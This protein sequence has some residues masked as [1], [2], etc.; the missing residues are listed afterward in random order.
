MSSYDPDNS[1]PPRI[2]SQSTDQPPQTEQQSRVITPARI[3]EYIGF[4]QCPR[5]FKHTV[6]EINSSL[7]HDGGEFQESF[8]PLNILL[9]KAGEEFEE[10]VRDE[11]LS[12]EEALVDL[13]R[14]AEYFAPDDD[15]I[16]EVLKSACESPATSTEPTIL[17]Q[18][19][20][21]DR[22]GGWQVAGDADL[23]LSW[24]TDDGAKARVIHVKSAQEK[25]SYHQIQAATY[26]DLLRRLVESSGRLESDR[27]EYSGGI[28]TREAAY[29]PPSPDVVPSFDVDPRITDVRRLL[30]PDGALASLA[31]ERFENVPYQLNDKCANCAYNENCLTDAYE[32]GH[33][34]LLG[35]SPAQQATLREE[36]GIETVDDLA[37]LAR[38]PAPED[39]Y[40]TEYSGASW[41]KETY[42]QLKST[43]GI[44]EQLPTLLY[45]AKAMAD[46][47]D[48]EGGDIIGRPVPWVLGTGRCPLPEDEPPEGTNISHDWLHGSMVRVYLNVQVD[49]LRDRLLQLSARVSAPTHVGGRGRRSQLH[50]L[51]RQAG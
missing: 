35:L 22:I 1:T 48:P 11:I 40:P 14:D 20:F 49:Y 5:Y 2:D 50:S 32:D 33:L 24:P 15:A 25:K 38:P 44:G 19:S 46:Y 45:R 18:A 36:H 23:I 26:L 31:E 17:Y 12:S 47:L 9:T 8:Q 27:I 42:R 4:E 34:R 28:I 43:P 37:N 3:G 7:H 51:C 29:K 30:A 39:W 16:I 6:Q 21:V 10:R 13:S 41:E